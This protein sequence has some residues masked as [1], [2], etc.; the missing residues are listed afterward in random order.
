MR[1]LC[2]SNT[3]SISGSAKRCVKCC[4]QFKPEQ[5]SALDLGFVAGRR[6][7]LRQ[8]GVVL[9]GTQFCD[10]EEPDDGLTEPP[11]SRPRQIE[12]PP[13]SI[14]MTSFQ[15]QKRSTHEAGHKKAV[16][17]RMPHAKV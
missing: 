9:Q 12:T 7:A 15:E 6:E 16:F 2:G 17:H 3:C 10:R 4:G 5:D 13:A 11:A 8:I 1:Y 14:L